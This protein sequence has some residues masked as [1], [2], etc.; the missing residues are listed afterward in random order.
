MKKMTTISHVELADG[1]KVDVLSGKIAREDSPELVEVPGALEAV[2]TVT[3]TKLRLIDL[4]LPP[5]QMNVVSVVLL[6]YLIGLSLEETAIALKLSEEQVARIRMSD[7]FAELKKKATDSIIE[8]DAENVRGLFTKHAISA[9]RGLANLMHS[10]DDKIRITAMKD[11][12]DR[13]GHRPADVVEH[14]H[15]VDG[16]L[17]IEYVEKKQESVP[18]IDMTSD[19]EF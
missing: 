8:H 10:D 4:P 18:I 2:E 7:A 15:T 6:Y 16:G 5:K 3:R 1:R 14:R 11:I 13:A 12:L 19:G 17:R 9:A